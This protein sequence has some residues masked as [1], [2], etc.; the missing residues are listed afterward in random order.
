MGTRA[1][2][3]D[4]YDRL[5]VAFRTSNQSYANASR[6]AGCTEGTA[7]KAFNKGWP[8]KGWLPVKQV[9]LE[10][11]LAARSALQRAALA[12]AE[13]QEKEREQARQQA[14]QSRQQEGQMVTLLR[15][16]ALQGAA[17]AGQL[18]KGARALSTQVTKQLE[19][20]AKAVPGAELPAGARLALIQRALS[21]SEAV[22]R[23]SAETMKMERLYLGEPTDVIAHIDLTAADMTGAELET[24]AA[25]FADAVRSYNERK[26]RLARHHNEDWFGETDGGEPPIDHDADD[27]FG[28]A[29]TVPAAEGAPNAAPAEPAPANGGARL[30]GVAVLT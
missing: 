16:N 18:L 1:I 29:I 24:R 15:T 7:K 20:E 2:T 27:D 11:Q 4:L 25:G 21:V 5:I 28:G 26:K 8:R 12:K 30:P 10:E 22:V 9:L 6:L 19:D 13:M 3:Q 23:A 14:V 17:L